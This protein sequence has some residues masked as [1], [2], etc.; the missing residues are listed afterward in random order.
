MG[1]NNDNQ[2]PS[3]PLGAGVIDT[4]EQASKGD[5]SNIPVPEP[6]IAR[7]TYIQHQRNLGATEFIQDPTEIERFNP[8]VIEYPFAVQAQIHMENTL[9]RGISYN[10]VHSKQTGEGLGDWFWKLLSLEQN[11]ESRMATIEEKQKSGVDIN[12]DYTLTQ[13]VEKVRFR[14]ELQSLEKAAIAVDEH[15]SFWEHVGAFWGGTM[16]T[17]FVTDPV[18]ILTMVFTSPLGGLATVGATRLAATGMPK[19]VASLISAGATYSF[20][21]IPQIYWMHQHAKEN[22]LQFNAPF[23][24]GMSMLLPAFLGSFGIM[25]RMPKAKKAAGP[26]PD[27]K[28]PKFT[29][30]YPEQPGATS[31]ALIIREGELSPYVGSQKGPIIKGEKIIDPFEISA[32][33]RPQLEAQKKTIT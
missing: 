30:L 23:A 28:S 25:R 21:D 12:E 33:T 20:M 29:R 18:A 11:T 27:I 26:E 19:F 8:V 16:L 32:P 13:L 1:N 24:Y 5:I 15:S 31:R 17:A 7:D 2:N 10:F 4:A 6:S 14:E 9:K 22:G 3:S